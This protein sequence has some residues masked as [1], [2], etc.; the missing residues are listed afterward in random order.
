MQRRRDFPCIIN[1]GKILMSF[2]FFLFISFSCAK[3]I[4]N[5]TDFSVLLAFKSSSDSSNALSSWILNSN[6]CSA[7]VGVNCHPAT[8]GVTKLVLN[9]FNLT[10][11]IQILAQLPQLRHLSL[12]HNRLSSTLN[13]TSW[14]KLRHLYLSHNHFTGEF[15]PGI[16]HLRGLRRLD[17]SYNGFF[18]KIPLAELTPLTHLLTLRLEFNSFNGTLPSIIESSLSSISDFNVSENSLA[19]K[20]PDGFSNFPASAFAGNVHLCGKPLPTNCPIKPITSDPSVGRGP[21]PIGVTDIKKKKQ[22]SRNEKILMIIVADTVAILLIILSI[23]CCCYYKKS[24]KNQNRKDSLKTFNSRGIRIYGSTT[25]GNVRNGEMVCFEG[26]KGFSKVDELLKAS[27]EM[28]GKG[29]VGTSYRVVMDG[30]HSVVVKR[31]REKVKRAKEIGSYLRVIGGLRH[32]NVVSLRAYYSTKEELL[33]VYDF[34]QNGSLHSVLHGKFFL[35]FF[36]FYFY[37]SFYFF[38]KELA[39][40][41]LNYYYFNFLSSLF[42][43]FVYNYDLLFFFFYND[44]EI[45]Y[46]YF[47]L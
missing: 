28:L 24:F 14:P 22:S 5:T 8:H 1:G 13:F 38:F 35:L 4:N 25:M 39:I 20:I 31:V 16:S 9:N 19:G 17:L 27:A 42:L 10:G 21:L 3:P 18:G 2:V 26:C 23:V 40:L 29:S 46:F 32:A 30:G 44:N 45:N 15:P 11:S 34:L 33:L 6:P 41:T 12:H 7:W 36:Y 43:L 37:I 47:Y